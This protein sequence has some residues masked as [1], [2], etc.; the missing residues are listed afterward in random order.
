MKVPKSIA[1]IRDENSYEY[2][3][4]IHD[5]WNRFA[6]HSSFLDE[7]HRARHT[8]FNEGFTLAMERA[9]KL[10]KALDGIE[11][12]MLEGLLVRNTENDHDIQKMMNESSRVVSH[13]CAVKSALEEWRKEMVDEPTCDKSN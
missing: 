6:K 9:E 8:G 13:L 2:I 11:T 7:I 4:N 10:V 3:Q 5:N 12:L 1:K